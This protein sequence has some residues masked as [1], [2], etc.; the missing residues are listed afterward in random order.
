MSAV[1]DVAIGLVVV[2]LLFSI[3]VSGIN[4]WWAQVRSRRGEFLRLGMQRLIDDTAIY[5]RVLHHPL[6]GSLYRTRAAQGKPP[7]YVDPKN[8]AM[9][10]ADVL[11]ARSGNRTSA[12]ATRS[13]LTV[14]ML[15]NA[16]SSPALIASRAGTSPI[17][18]RPYSSLV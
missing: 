16:L 3:A 13:T 17:R 15:Q 7:S 10:I 1:L 4:E 2:F 5:N 8:F 6:I 12:T 18:I 11:V 9:A 14:E